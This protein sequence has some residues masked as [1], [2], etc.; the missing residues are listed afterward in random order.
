MNGTSK[1]VKTL[2]QKK[3]K[4]STIA[5]LVG[6][7]FGCII[8]CTTERFVLLHALQLLGGSWF[9]LLD[10]SV[11]SLFSSED[12]LVCEKENKQSEIVV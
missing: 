2:Y 6:V 4:K 10:Y 7:P 5:N 11:F 8:Q 12:F 9:G 3:K 1:R